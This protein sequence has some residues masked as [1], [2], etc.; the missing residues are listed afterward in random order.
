M[1]LKIE[2][3]ELLPKEFK[4]QDIDE[5]FFRAYNKRKGSGSNPKSFIFPKMIG[6]DQELV[7][8]IAMYIGDGKLSDDKYH[9]DFTSKDSDMVKFM[10]C[11]FT[12]RLNLNL[13]DIR[14]TVTY[15]NLCEY[16]IEKWA[17]YMSIPKN[18]INLKQSDRHGYECFGMQIG[19]RILRAVFGKM[20]NKILELDFTDNETLRRAF[21]RGLFAAEGGIGI[22]KK[23]NYIAYMAYHLSYKKEK[24]L[25]NFVQRLLKLESISSKQ[26]TRKNKGERYIQITNWQNYWRMHKI[27][28]FDLSQRKKKKFLDHVENMNFYCKISNKLRDILLDNVKLRRPSILHKDRIIKTNYMSLKNI[29]L[30][31]SLKELPLEFIKDNVNETRTRNSFVIKDKDFIDFIFDL[32]NFS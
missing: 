5:N 22:V 25:A 14:Y 29:V 32:K 13:D 27:G 11:F 9:L 21:L 16:S 31:S 4:I 10:F 17:V 19:G 8:A 30:L 3:T 23:E 7:E 18:Y 2:L 26:I 28:V 24:K 12:K 1:N 6:I 15:K 20:V